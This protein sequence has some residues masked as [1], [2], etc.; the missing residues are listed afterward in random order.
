MLLHGS[1]SNWLSKIPKRTVTRL[2]PCSRPSSSSTSTS[3][4]ANS[5]PNASLD[6]FSWWFFVFTYYFVLVVLNKKF[7]L[8]LNF[9]VHNPSI[10]YRIPGS[11]LFVY[12]WWNQV[13][14]HLWS[15][16]FFSFFIFSFFHNQ[17]FRFFDYFCPLI[18]NDLFGSTLKT[19]VLCIC[20]CNMFASVVDIFFS[21]QINWERERELQ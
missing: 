13:Q 15:L 3:S 5:S 18:V 4:N 2:H 21:S 17:L 9:A 14:L 16:F 10:V 12:F 7:F 1:S 11:L 6:G 20:M 19:F 8:I